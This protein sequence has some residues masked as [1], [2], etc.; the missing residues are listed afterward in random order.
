M[1]KHLVLLAKVLLFAFA[2]GS[3]GAD[4]LVVPLEGGKILDGSGAD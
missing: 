4:L 2:L 1:R 3:L